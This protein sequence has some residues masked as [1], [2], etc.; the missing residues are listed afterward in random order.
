MAPGERREITLLPSLWHFRTRHEPRAL[1]T[2]TVTKAAQ[3]EEVDAEGGKRAAIRWTWEL[4]D[5]QQTVWVEEAYPHRILAWRD[6]EGSSGQLV[7]SLRVP[8]WRLNDNADEIYRE[9]LNIP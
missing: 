7:K 8:Y 4:E 9:Q 1:A 5:R 2:A 3:T 6:S